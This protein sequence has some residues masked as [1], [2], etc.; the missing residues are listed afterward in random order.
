MDRVGDSGG[1]ALAILVGTIAHA[2]GDGLTKHGVPWLE[3]FSS[4]VF[5]L[6]P[7]CLRISTGHATERFLIAPA[8][9]LALA[10]LAYHAITLT[11]PPTSR[12]P[13]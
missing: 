7:K 8:F 11:P 6:L 4:H 12:S 9:L 10:F 1:I 2:A 5:H 13:A 3:P